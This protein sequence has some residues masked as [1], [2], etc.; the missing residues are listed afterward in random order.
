MH[1]YTS[2]N[3]MVLSGSS[4][5]EPA[6]GAARAIAPA[7]T[8]DDVVVAKPSEITRGPQLNWLASEVRF[9]SSVINIVLGRQDVGKAIMRHPAVRKVPLRLSGSWARHRTYCGESRY[10][11]IGT[12]RQIRKYRV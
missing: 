10:P 11:D 3:P 8:A 9:P 5:L 7:L 12:W 2:A 1:V 4:P 6:S